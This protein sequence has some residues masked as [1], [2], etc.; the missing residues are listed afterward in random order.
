M[1]SWLIRGTPYRNAG[2]WVKIKV[3]HTFCFHCSSWRVQKRTH[4]KPH[5]TE[6]SPRLHSDHRSRRSGLYPPWCAPLSQ[7]KRVLFL[8]SCTTLLIRTQEGSYSQGDMKDNSSTLLLDR[9]LQPTRSRKLI[10]DIDLQFDLWERLGQLGIAKSVSARLQ[11][12]S[13]NTILDG[14]G[15]MT[16]DF[17]WHKSAV[18]RRGLLTEHVSG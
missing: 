3:T 13:G 17:H 12:C 8:K 7:G 5:N 16:I 4:K 9:T 2:L 14:E 18:D 10:T 1:S 15:R 11:P 6:K